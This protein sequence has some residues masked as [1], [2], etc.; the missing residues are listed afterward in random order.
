ME[1]AEGV[2]D[3]FCQNFPIISQALHWN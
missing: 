2:R 1:I 3:I